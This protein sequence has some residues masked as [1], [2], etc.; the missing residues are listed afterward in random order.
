MGLPFQKLIIASNE[1][2]ILTRFIHDGDYSTKDVTQT[3]APS[4]DIQVASNFE[5]MLFD[6][7]SKDSSRLNKMMDEFT[8]TGV[9]PKLSD[10]EMAKMRSIFNASSA[11]EEEVHVAMHEAYEKYG[12][13]IDPHTAVGLAAVYA[14]PG[15][16]PA[17]CF[18][19]AHPAKFPD[20]VEAGT[21]VRPELPQRLQ[22]ILKADEV[23]DT[24]PND[25]NAI[26]DYINQYV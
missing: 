8:T 17:L 3:C 26:K 10:N 6:V 16:R 5:R 23:F 13:L 1:N 15:M 20:A 14:R 9:L 2:D 24:V 21:G 22:H 11:S 18:S 25:I 19:T 4:I 7:I 12:I